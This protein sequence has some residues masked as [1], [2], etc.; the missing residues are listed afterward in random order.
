MDKEHYIQKSLQH[1]K[2]WWNNDFNSH[3]VF[4]ENVDCDSLTRINK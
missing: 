4:Q 3:V 2:T 1:S